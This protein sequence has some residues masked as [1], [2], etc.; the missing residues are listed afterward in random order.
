MDYRLIDFS[1]LRQNVVTRSVIDHG[2]WQRLKLFE[3]GKL[4][5]HESYTSLA[6]IFVSEIIRANLPYPRH[7][8]SISEC[9][10]G[11]LHLSTHQIE[12]DT[13]KN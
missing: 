5:N 12:T 1:I 10:G 11:E 9:N 4:F 2:Y 3:V 6:D 7:P 8:R 13:C